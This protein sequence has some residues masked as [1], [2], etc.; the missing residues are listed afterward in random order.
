M[1]AELGKWIRWSLFTLLTVAFAGAVQRYKIAFPLPFIDQRNLMHAH[2]HLAFAGW[3][4]QVLMALMV[5]YLA[6]NSMPDAFRKYNWLLWANLISA[7]GMFVTF[8]MGGFDVYSIGFST[9]TVIVSYI[10]GIMYWHDL[11]RLKEKS[12][13]HSWIKA[14]IVFSIISSLGGFALGMMMSMKAFHQMWFLGAVYFFM[15]FQYNGWFFFAIMGLLME[16]LVIKSVSTQAL[17]IIFIIYAAS[18]VPTYFLSALWIPVPWWTYWLM[19]FSAAAQFIGWFWIVKIIHSN[20]SELTQNMS[21]LGK[22][23]IVLPMAALFIKFIL[24]LTAAHPGLTKIAYEFHSIVIGFLHLVF[25]AISTLFILGY[26]IINNL[27]AVS[28]VTKKGIIVFTTGIIFSE[29]LLMSQGVAAL[30]LK[31]IPYMEVYLFLSALIMFTGV[32][33]IN[34]NPGAALPEPASE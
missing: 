31:T 28:S 9:V 21:L 26:I 19:V 25:L 3:I 5:N 7:W 10:F 8:I 33:M 12:I 14:A 16:K 4:T 6:K 30:F 32:L 20:I 27:M 1:N 29:L 13:V 18:C 2:S 22:W 17:K 24:Q 15:H 34:L 11:N 23:L